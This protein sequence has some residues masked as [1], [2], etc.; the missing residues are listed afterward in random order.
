LSGSAAYD[1]ALFE[2]LKKDGVIEIFI[3]RDGLLKPGRSFHYIHPSGRHS[4][5]FLRAANVM[6]AGPEVTFL[7][8]SLLRYLDAEPYHLWVDTSSIAG[9]AYALI[10]LRQTL[11]PDFRV[12]AINSFSSYGGVDSTPFDDGA[13]SLVLISATTSGNLARKIAKKGFASDHI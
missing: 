1:E 13:R 3:R 9:I 5:G 6:M 11:Q 10:A 7:A 4:R 12:P 2:S 8:M